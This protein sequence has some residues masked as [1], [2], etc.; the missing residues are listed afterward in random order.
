MVEEENIDA[1][2]LKRGLSLVDKSCNV[3]GFYDGARAL[4]F[5]RNFSAFDGKV[6]D[7]IVTEL[8]FLKIDGRKIIRAIRANALLK[9]VP[10]IVMSA[11]IEHKQIIELYNL[12]SNS[13]L[14]KPITD[15]GISHILSFIEER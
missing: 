2:I 10:I 6:P 14:Y 13:F 1:F 3:R 8:K 7:L 4:A 9:A 11:T 15:K 5:F 12:G